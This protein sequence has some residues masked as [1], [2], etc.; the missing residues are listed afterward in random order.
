MQQ[1]KFPCFLPVVKLSISLEEEN[2]EETWE[3]GLIHLCFT[4]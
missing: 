4:C 2:M 1:E 3:G